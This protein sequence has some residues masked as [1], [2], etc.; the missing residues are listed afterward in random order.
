MLQPD[1]STEFQTSGRKQKLPGTG[2]ETQNYPNRAR[3]QN[4]KQPDQ[5]GLAGPQTDQKT[6][7][8]GVQVG[9]SEVVPCRHRVQVEGSE[10][11]PCTQ[12]S[13][14][15]RRRRPMQT[16]SDG[17][18]QWSRLSRGR[19]GPWRAVQKLQGPWR[20]VQKPL[21]PWRAVQKLLG[22]LVGSGDLWRSPEDLRQSPRDLRQ[23]R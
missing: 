20:V 22:P 2:P 16:R 15:R 1:Q 17:L 3:K 10:V 19:L 18:G 4:Q 7:Q 14:R 21:G 12:S 8:N 6:K 11:F 13:G 23:S 5:S 9:D